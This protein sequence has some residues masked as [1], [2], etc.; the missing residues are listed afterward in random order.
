MCF[1]HDAEENL[2]MAQEILSGIDGETGEGSHNNACSI[3]ILDSQGFPVAGLLYYNKTEYNIFLTTRIY[4]PTKVT[5]EKLHQ[6][7]AFAFEDPIN[8]YRIT[9]LVSSTNQ[10]SQMFVEKL[11]FHKE[12]EC[13]GFDGTEEDVTF[14]YRYTQKDWYGSKFYGKENF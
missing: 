11:G 9:A 13:I 2:Q 4:Q 1:P 8:V 5:K 10:R 14:V 3:F 7:F 12:G 6:T